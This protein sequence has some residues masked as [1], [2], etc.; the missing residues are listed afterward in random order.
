[1]SIFKKTIGY[2]ASGA[3]NV[4][5][6]LG[7]ATIPGGALGGDDVMEFHVEVG[8]QIVNG[9]AETSKVRLNA[10]VLVTV[11]Y[12]GGAQG[13]AAVVKGKLWRTG[14]TTAAL[15]DVVVRYSDPDVGTSYPADAT[16]SGL[17]FSSQQTFD[18]RGI[19]GSE[20][21]VFLKRAG[22]EY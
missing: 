14:A 7:S 16:I 13:M 3:A 12:L 5:V 4:E 20:G 8:G 18:V 9:G 21:G 17:A 19:A 2:G 22:V 10:Q 11:P 6:T 15:T 1:M